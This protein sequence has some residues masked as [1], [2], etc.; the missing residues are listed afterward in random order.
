[1]FNYSLLV[2]GPEIETAGLSFR[3]NI[4]WSQDTA[5]FSEI[6]AKI[7]KPVKKKKKN[8]GEST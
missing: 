6:S 5:K 8:Y 4:R 2:L 1:M 3:E 7:K